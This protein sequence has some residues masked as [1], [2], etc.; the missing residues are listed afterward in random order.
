[1][2]PPAVFAVF[3]PHVKLLLLLSQR[4]TML[5]VC[6]CALPVIPVCTVCV[7]SPREEEGKGT[8]PPDGKKQ[9]CMWM[10]AERKGGPGTVGPLIL[11]Q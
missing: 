10:K 2:R 5:A 8:A 4:G 6:M 11:S 9:H 1:M 7:N 3:V